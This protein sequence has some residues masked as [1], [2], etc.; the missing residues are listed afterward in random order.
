MVVTHHI[1]TISTTLKLKMEETSS[2]SGVLRRR[3]RLSKLLSFFTLEVRNEDTQDDQSGVGIQLVCEGWIPSRSVVAG[4][5]VTVTGKWEKHGPLN[6]DRFFVEEDGFVVESEEIV[7]SS[8]WEKAAMHAEWR[9]R[10]GAT[11]TCSDPYCPKSHGDPQRWEARRELVAQRRAE[12]QVCADC[13][14]SESATTKAQHN[15]TFAMWVIETF[16]D[17]ALRQGVVDIAGGRGIVGL[18]LMLRQNLRHVALVE[19]R[20]LRVNSTY[21][22][23]LRK[24]RVKNAEAES[25]KSSFENDK[26]ELSTE[27]ALSSVGDLESFDGVLHTEQSG[28]DTDKPV[29]TDMSPFHPLQHFKEEFY[30]LDSASEELRGVLNAAGV[31]VAVHPDAATGA[32]V[33]TAIV[34]NKPFAIVPCCVFTNM[35]PHR[36]TA[37]GKPVTTYEELLDYLQALG[38]DDVRRG[39]LPF[40]GRNIV[41]YRL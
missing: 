25:A 15:Y 39:H 7:C 34:L 10:Y 38:G 21:R 40:Q 6:E 33:E 28:E 19:P 9:K 4:K 35:F 13:D 2:I 16:Q 20:E 18:E 41:L 3:R 5:I 32:V 36:K 26:S 31:L 17:S 11:C 29:S 1:H 12:R 24:W 27:S 22:R 30:G 14:H 23:R 37:D 8:N